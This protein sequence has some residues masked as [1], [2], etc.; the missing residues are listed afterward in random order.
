MLYYTSGCQKLGGHVG[1][2][3][4]EFSRDPKLT[5]AA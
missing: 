1:S 5:S 3:R 4:G 2:K